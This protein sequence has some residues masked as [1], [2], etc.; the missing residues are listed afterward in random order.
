[1][2]L[3][4]S[5]MH[6]LGDDLMLVEL[7]SQHAFINP[8]QVQQWSSRARG[9]GFKRFVLIEVPRQPEVDFSCRVYA[10]DG[11]ELDCSFVDLCCVTRL[12]MEKK[13]T[14]QP[15]LRFD[16]RTGQQ[17]TCLS[18]DGWVSVEYPLQNFTQLEFAQSWQVDLGENYQDTNLAAALSVKQQDGQHNKLRLELVKDELSLSLC[19][20]QQKVELRGLATRTFEGQIRI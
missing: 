10:Q 19:F 17:N 11:T 1:M 4:F 6:C 12:L 15:E 16:T 9:V 2:L 3:R 8:R 13:L 18:I 5:K 20:E 7:L 14:T